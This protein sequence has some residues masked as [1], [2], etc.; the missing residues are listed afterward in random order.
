MNWTEKLVAMAIVALFIAGMLLL[1][2]YLCLL[3]ILTLFV[4]AV[5]QG[6][7]QAVRHPISH[8]R[9][10]WYRA[11][12]THD[13]GIINLRVFSHDVVQVIAL[14]CKAEGCPPRAIKRVCRVYG[15]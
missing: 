8:K 3:S 15:S 14:I 5:W 7:A 9:M 2:Q 1:N 4:G 12:V 11:T 6:G 10:R 13:K